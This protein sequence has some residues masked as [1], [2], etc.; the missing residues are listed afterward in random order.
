MESSLEKKL[1]QQRREKLQRIASQSVGRLL[2]GL[3]VTN[4]ISLRSYY[5]ALVRSQLY[6]PS[7]SLFSCA[8]YERSQKVFLENI[9]SLPHSYPIHVACFFMGIPDFYLFFFDA[10]ISFIQRLARRGSLASLSART[11]DREELLQLGVGWNAELINTLLEVMDIREVDLLDDM[12]KF[13]K[14]AR[15]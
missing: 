7:F 12:S 4:F 9:F 6:R 14:C 15:N 10:R 2:R 5:M 1:H 8:E 3:E 11:I 13:L